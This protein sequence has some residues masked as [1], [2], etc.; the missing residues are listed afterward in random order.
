MR[1]K[2]LA[3]LCAGTLAGTLL[4]AIGV[5][6]AFAEYMSFDVDTTSIS[7]AGERTVKERTVELGEGETA[8]ITDDFA[9]IVFDEAIEPGTLSV[10]V[11]YNSEFVMPSID[12][13]HRQSGTALVGI[14]P[15]YLSGE[16]D[17]LI[18]NKDFVLDQLKRH[19]LVVPRTD[20]ETST[21]VKANPADEDRIRY[22][23]E[24]DYYES[25]SHDADRDSSNSLEDAGSSSSL[26]SA[27]RSN[28][29]EGAGSQNSADPADAEP[30]TDVSDETADDASDP[31]PAD[32]G[33]PGFRTSPAAPTAPTA[34]SSDAS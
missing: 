9:E 25:S 14:T 20:Y 8:L 31:D 6:V 26:N 29:P 21:T 33:S 28:V 2:P 1:N 10:S 4:G 15:R 32:T 7:D 30:E 18:E 23:S 24:S 27:S 34:P 17:Q 16:M 13:V 5:G 11:E 3:I 12:V 22:A 19:V